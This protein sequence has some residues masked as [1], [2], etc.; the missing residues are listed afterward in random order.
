[1]GLYDVWLVSLLS[2]DSVLPAGLLFALH[3]I[4]TEAVSHPHSDPVI[5]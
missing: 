2:P 1:M 4:H 3:P 5:D